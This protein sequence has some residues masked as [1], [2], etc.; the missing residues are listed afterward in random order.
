MDAGSQYEIVN[1]IREYPEATTLRRAAHE[2]HA[3]RATSVR[4]PHDRFAQAR[5]RQKEA[6]LYKAADD[7]SKAVQ[8]R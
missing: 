6:Q 8:R 1:A 7:F 4:C 2:Y 3:A 5:M